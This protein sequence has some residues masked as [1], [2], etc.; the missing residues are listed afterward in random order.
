MDEGGRAD[1]LTARRIF[2]LHESTC[3]PLRSQPHLRVDARGP[4][5]KLAV[6]IRISRRKKSMP[7]KRATMAATKSDATG[8][9]ASIRE[10]CEHAGDA[11][12]QEHRRDGELDRVSDGGDA[13]VL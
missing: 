1:A 2:G 4:I 11:R 5:C 3:A 10:N 13:S 12:Q 9:E 6:A 7:T 8:T